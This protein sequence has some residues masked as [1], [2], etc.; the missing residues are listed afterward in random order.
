MAEQNTR[1]GGYTSFADMFDGGGPGASG[2]PFKGGGLLSA[3]GNALTNNRGMGVGPEAGVG[4]AGYGYNDA[5]GNWVPASVDMRNG[6]G[7]GQ[8]G[9]YFQGGGM[10]SGILN[11]LGVRPMGYNATA[12]SMAPMGGGG[13]GGGMRNPALAPLTSIVPQMAPNRPLPDG[14]GA[15]P[16]SNYVPSTA[17]LSA[18]RPDGIGATPATAYAGSQALIDTAAQ[19]AAAAA[20]APTSSRRSASAPA[21]ITGNPNDVYATMLQS[22]QRF[23]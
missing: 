1:S 10:Y 16:V 2:G 3:I 6:G 8:S 22:M 15:T 11:M 20:A 5:S 9:P 21:Y 18:P 23:R 13:D 4:F 17:A 19:N 7:P 14:T 12:S